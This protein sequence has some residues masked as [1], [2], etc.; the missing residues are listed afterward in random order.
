VIS[1]TD[2]SAN[3]RWLCRG[4]RGHNG[5]EAERVLGPERILRARR[6]REVMSALRRLGFAQREATR[7][8]RTA[9][10]RATDLALA[11]LLRQALQ[12]VHPTS[13]FEADGRGREGR[14]P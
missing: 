5:Y 11:P 14:Q 7:A 13:G 10:L 12:L 9:V 8:S 1:R 4:R 2:D 3:L 6:Q